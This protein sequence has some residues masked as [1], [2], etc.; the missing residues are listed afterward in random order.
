MFEVFPIMR[1]LHELRWYLTEALTLQQARPLHDELRLALGE[2]ERPSDSSADALLKLDLA[3]HRR[4]VNALL[5]RTSEL[6][7]AE[8]RHEHLSH[9]VPAG[10]GEGRF[11]DPVAAVAHSPSALAAIGHAVDDPR[12][13]DRRAG[14]HHDRPSDMGIASS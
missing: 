10:C 2:T 1:D 14:P 12:L 4:D 5:L 3:A 9:P 13:T 6:V 7:R 8:V 11:R